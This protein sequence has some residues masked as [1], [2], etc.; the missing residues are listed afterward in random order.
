MCVLFIL[1]CIGAYFTRRCFIL[2]IPLCAFAFF[3]LFVG[4]G[5]FCSHKKNIQSL[6]TNSFNYHFLDIK[7]CVPGKKYVHDV[8]YELN[9]YEYTAPSMFLNATRIHVFDCDGI[10]LTLVPRP[11]KTDESERKD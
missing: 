4:F 6:K 9:R 2:C 5:L 11:P 10:H 3:V 8:I 7:R 1:L